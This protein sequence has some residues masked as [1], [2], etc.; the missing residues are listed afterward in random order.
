MWV[1]RLGKTLPGQFEAQDMTGEGAFR[2]GGRWNSAG[3]R[4]VYASLNPATAVL[5]SI[6]HL[7]QLLNPIDRYLITIE[8]PDD[9]WNDS[10]TGVTRA[11][12]LPAHWDAIPHHQATMLYGNKWLKKGKQLGIL[13]PSAVLEEEMNIVLNPHHPAMKRLRIRKSRPFVFDPRLK[14]IGE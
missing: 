3:H 5:E 9:L 8:I 7:G 1:W 14:G 6:V 12:R 11:K 4:A 2:Y 13:V 10:A